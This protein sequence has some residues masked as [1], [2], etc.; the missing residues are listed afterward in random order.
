[1]APGEQAHIT[2]LQSERKPIGDRQYLSRDEFAKAL[3]GAAR[4]E[5]EPQVADRLEVLPFHGSAN[6]FTQRMSAGGQ[7]VFELAAR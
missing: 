1:M 6:V 2:L 4:R 7:L 3:A 5:S